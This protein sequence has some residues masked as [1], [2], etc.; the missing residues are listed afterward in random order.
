MKKRNH[1]A[2]L[3]N[4]ARTNEHGQSLLEALLWISL[5]V[6]VACGIASGFAAERSRYR[7]SLKRGL[8]S[9]SVERLAGG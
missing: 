8:P 3:W 5:V 4:G 2:G 6:L 7:A 9:S 1:G